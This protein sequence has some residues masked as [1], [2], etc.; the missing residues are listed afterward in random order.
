[1]N[2]VITP[3]LSSDQERSSDEQLLS[4]DEPTGW[5]KIPLLSI[6][7]W[8]VWTYILTM[9]IRWLHLDANLRDSSMQYQE[10]RWT[11]D[12]LCQLRPEV[13]SRLFYFCHQNQNHNR[14]YNRKNRNRRHNIDR[15]IN[16]DFIL[17]GSQY[18]SV[19][20]ASEQ[21]RISIFST[22]DNEKEGNASTKSW[23]NYNFADQLLST[24][25]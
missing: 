8:P 2:K 9:K 21:V 4:T 16:I 1:M 17:S 3:T 12:H 20:M 6:R 19:V 18:S 10:Q 7:P 24:I 23:G 22:Y 5:A 25:S 14:H 15:H 11:V 13:H